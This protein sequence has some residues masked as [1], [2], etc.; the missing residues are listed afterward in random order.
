MSFLTSK[1][2]AFKAPSRSAGFG[3]KLLALLLGTLVL[4]YLSTELVLPGLEGLTL[5]AAGMNLLKLARDLLP[6]LY[7]FV[8]GTVG[9]LWTTYLLKLPVKM[10]VPDLPV[11]PTI[12][13]MVFTFIA[14]AVYLNVLPRMVTEATSATY[15]AVVYV[16]LAALLFPFCVTFFSWMEDPDDI[17]MEVVGLCVVVFMGFLSFTLTGE[18]A[19]TAAVRRLVLVPHVLAHVVAVWGAFYYLLLYKDDWRAGIRM[20][21]GADR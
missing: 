5:L 11:G 1:F 18:A 6:V 7:P 8:V 15:L 9:V 4:T 21:S 17:R 20:P 10:E 3:A 13:G 12:L 19:Q 14:G 2:N 16:S